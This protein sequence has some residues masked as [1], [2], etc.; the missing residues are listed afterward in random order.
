MKLSLVHQTGGKDMMTGFI[1]GIMGKLNELREKV[2]NIADN[3]R[4]Q[5]HFSRPDERTIKG[6]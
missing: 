3:I 6:L 1:N 4:A 2:R 5:L